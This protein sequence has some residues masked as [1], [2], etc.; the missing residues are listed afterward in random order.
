MRYL[1]LR[2]AWSVSCG[3]V[4]AAILLLCTRSFWHRD[5]LTT[6][7]GDTI[8]ESW[9]GRLGL[10]IPPSNISNF[11]WQL[12]SEPTDAR[13]ERMDQTNLRPDPGFFQFYKLADRPGIVAPHAYFVFLTVF[14]AWAPY[15]QWR[16][17]FRALVASIRTAFR[18]LKSFRIRN[19][20][21]FTWHACCGLAC[22]LLIFLWMRSYHV[23]DGVCGMQSP[24][25]TQAR[26]TILAN[27]G[28]FGVEAYPNFF[29]IS[30]V[31]YCKF[32][33]QVPDHKSYSQ[34]TPFYARLATGVTELYIPIWI[35]V[36]LAVLCGAFPSFAGQ[37]HFSLRTLLIVTTLTAL[38]LGITALYR[39]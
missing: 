23:A 15:I 19:K 34:L 1:K 28:F 20:W 30:K 16:R 14:L 37:I 26:F 3:I 2:I 22:V 35:M 5:A 18:S 38:A 33:H 39:Q 21:K 24:K 32:E 17:N 27:S 11:R 36:L 31:R 9:R 7:T 29:A 6:S 25:N 13:L 8:A 4:G 12:I 10:N